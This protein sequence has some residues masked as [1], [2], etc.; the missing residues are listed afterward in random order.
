V[1]SYE[2]QAP[3][4]APVS[5]VR[6]GYLPFTHPEG[7]SYVPLPFPAPAAITVPVTARLALHAIGQTVTTTI[8]LTTTAS[9]DAG[10]P[11]PPDAAAHHLLPADL[12]FGH[13]VRLTHVALDAD[14]YRPGDSIALTLHWQ[15]LTQDPVDNHVVF[16][17]LEQEGQQAVATADMSLG[18]PA[19]WKL[20]ETA[21]VQRLQRIP[22]EA[23][24]G[25]YRLVLGVYDARAKEFLPVIANDGNP[26]W[27]TFQTAITLR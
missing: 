10:L 12:N 19:A 15:K 6:E 7:I 5:G 13:R 22:L 23:P 18:V 20:G 24:P 8:A 21:A 11:M 3:G 4:A 25:P 26:Q 2:W 16:F 27:A 1:L 9:Y 17:R 14:T